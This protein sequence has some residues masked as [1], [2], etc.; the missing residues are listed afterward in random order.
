MKK[1]AHA[2]TNEELRLIKYAL[3]NVVADAGFKLDDAQALLIRLACGETRV[4]VHTVVEGGVLQSVQAT[5][6]LDLIRDDWDEQNTGE[7]VIR[8]EGSPDDVDW[9]GI[10]LP[11]LFEVIDFGPGPEDK[12]LDY[13]YVG[14]EE[15]CSRWIESRD[16]MTR[17]DGTN[18]YA[19]QEWCSVKQFD[20]NG[21]AMLPLP[22]E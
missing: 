21:G 7:P 5:A 9:D 11:H 22:K 8:H 17:P 18:R 13:P 20:E 10:P 4:R 14:T 1:T 6:D 2:L 16:D 3:N 15:Q 12:T 19:M